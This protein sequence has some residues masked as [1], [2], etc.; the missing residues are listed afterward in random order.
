MTT[1]KTHLVSSQG[2]MWLPAIFI[3]K[4]HWF[5]SLK[6]THVHKYLDSNV[7]FLILPQDHITRM[8][9]T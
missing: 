2:Y 8:G 4:R 3:N 6:H 5:N 7:L 1:Q 9:L